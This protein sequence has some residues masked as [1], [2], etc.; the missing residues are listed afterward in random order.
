[1]LTV[2]Q[3]KLIKPYNELSRR[4]LKSGKSRKSGQS[5]NDLIFQPRI[6]TVLH[7]GWGCDQF[8]GAGLGIYPPL[9][10]FLRADPLA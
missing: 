8:G 6:S 5:A 4:I 2:H 7:N 3:K 9:K 1:L 10:L